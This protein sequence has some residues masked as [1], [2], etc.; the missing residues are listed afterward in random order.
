[1]TVSLLRR[2]MA[3][4]DQVNHIV[5][6]MLE[7]RSFDSMLGMLYPA[8]ARF[9]GLLGT[10]TNL[11]PNGIPVPVWNS[12][13]TDRAAL[14]IPDPDPGEL[15]EDI[16]TQLFGTPTVPNPAPAPTMGGFVRNY[17]S[18]AMKAPGNYDAKAVMHYFSPKQVPVISELARQFATQ[19][20][21]R[22]TG[23]SRSVIAGLPR[24]LARPG[25]TAFLFTRAPRT[26]T[27]TTIRRAFPTRWIPCSISLNAPA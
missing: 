5:V 12:P 13:G 27:R 14:S 17:L 7:N 19:R 6:L 25:P 4:L 10:E 18:Q 11:D 22:A 3:Q 1:M 2:E 24:P 9:D 26:D 8:S 15:W 16:N 21:R 20:A 23:D